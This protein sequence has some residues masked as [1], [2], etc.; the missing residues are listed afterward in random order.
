VIVEEVVIEGVSVG[1]SVFVEVRENE[2]V[3][4]GVDVTV[5]V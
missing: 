5:L 2:I 4:D 3:D 1:V